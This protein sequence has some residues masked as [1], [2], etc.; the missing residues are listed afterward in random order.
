MGGGQRPGWA[1]G[2]A[3][4]CYLQEEAA[5]RCPRPGR[6]AGRP[7]SGAASPTPPSAPASH[8]PGPQTVDLIP[9]FSSTG[10]RLMAP[11]MCWVKHIP[12]QVEEAEGKVV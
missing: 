2:Q 6:R 9:V 8:S 1:P 12:V 7:C 5:Q 3:Y 10:T 4:I 11:S